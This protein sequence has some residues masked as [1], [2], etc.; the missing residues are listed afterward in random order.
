MIYFNDRS[1]EI[2]L[3]ASGAVLVKDFGETIGNLVIINNNDTAISIVTYKDNTNVI[4]GK[5]S[6]INGLLDFEKQVPKNKVA[7][8]NE[9][10]EDLVI[11]VMYGE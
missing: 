4:A 2:T 1:G 3:E 10:T 8:L 6:L 7:I 11:S 9:G 5:I